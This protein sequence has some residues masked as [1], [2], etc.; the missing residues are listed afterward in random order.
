MAYIQERHHAGEVVTGLL[1][2]RHDTGDLNDRMNT[3]DV[4]LNSLGEAD[5]CPGAGA[6]EAINAGLR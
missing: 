3:V 4:P 6:I 1:H 2:I 5:L